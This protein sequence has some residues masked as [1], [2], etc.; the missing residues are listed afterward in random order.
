MYKILVFLL[1]AFGFAGCATTGRVVPEAN[2]K[3]TELSMALDSAG[4]QSRQFYTDVQSLLQKTKALNDHPG[5][6]DMERIISGV[7]SLQDPEV[8]AFKVAESMPEMVEW[9]RRWNEPW[10]ELFLRYISLVD[11]SS[12]MEAKR[13]ALRGKLLTLQAGYL[14]AAASEFSAGRNTEG[15]T[16]YEMV[17]VLEGYVEELDF[18]TLSPSG[19]Y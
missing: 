18:Y 9:S 12:I 19:L 3:V 8:D 10:E 4:E 7:P 6:A 2:V 15:K 5:W 11:R 1:F 17:D 13:L 16:L 14:G